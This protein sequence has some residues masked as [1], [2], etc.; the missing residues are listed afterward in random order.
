MSIKH[1]TKESFESEVLKSA[2]PVLVD[3]WAEWCGP[4]K[5]I[6]PILDQIAEEYEG[7]LGIAKLDVEEAQNIAMQ[8]GV[9]SIPTLM[10]FK[11]G[12][13]EA[14]HVGMLSKDQLAK[15]LDEKL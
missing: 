6:A 15:M 3:F 12:V 5:M 8:F 9:R 4:C 10:L 14:Q 7:K 13:V 2:E 11:N 1:V